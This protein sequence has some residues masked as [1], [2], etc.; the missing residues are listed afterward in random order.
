MTRN[1]V[2][3]FKFLLFTIWT[4]AAAPLQAAVLRFNLGPGA[5]ILPHFWFARD[6]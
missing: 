2:A 5:Y 4:L 6:C 1:F 3:I